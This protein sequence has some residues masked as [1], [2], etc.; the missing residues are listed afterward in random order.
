MKNS[1]AS[2][3]SFT[4][5]VWRLLALLILLLT[6]ISALVPGASYASKGL[7]GEDSEDD[8]IQYKKSTP[9]DVITRLQQ[10]LDTGRLHLTPAGRQGVLQSLLKQLNI[11]IES[12]ILVFSKTSFQRELISPSNPRALYFNDTT[13]IG[14]VQGS[15]VIEVLTMDPKLGGVFYTLDQEH[16]GKLKFRRGTDECLQCH[17]TAMSNKVPGNIFRSVY[18]HAD[19]QPEFS[20]GSFLTDDTSPIEE[21]WGGWYVTGTHGAMRHMGN[22]VAKGVREN[23]TLDKNTGANITDLNRFFQTSHYLAPSSDIVA[24]LV[25]EHQTHI[26]NLI[27]K[28]GY[29]TRIA[30]RYDEALNRDLNRPSDYHSDSMRS[31]ITSVCEPLVHAMLFCGEQALANPIKGNGGYAAKFEKLGPA[32]TAG[33]SLRQLDLQT[34]LFKYRCSYLIYS[35]LFKGMPQR[36]KEFVYRRLNEVL[37]GA[38]TSKDFEHLSM[39]ERK[40]IVT[41]LESTSPEFVAYERAHSTPVKRP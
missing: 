33:K 21:R 12:Q 31:R 41:I 38:D 13:C 39:S 2:N 3:Y 9:T 25:A 8:A 6:G 15:P 17:E 7:D 26:Q 35:E 30:E 34:H 22:T 19:G 27:V 37:T 40:S 5:S 28:A 18:P 20:A 1:N 29:Q 16:A 24:L 10:D 14:W 32:D 36:A 11:P 4:V 23:I